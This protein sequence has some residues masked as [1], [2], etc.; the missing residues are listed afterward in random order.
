MPG[1]AGDRR[2]VPVALEAD[3]PEVPP[4][5]GLVVVDRRAGHRLAGADGRVAAPAEDGVE[6]EAHRVHALAVQRRRHELALTRALPVEQRGADAAGE[7]RARVVVAHPAA[8]ERQ[9]A[10]RRGEQ[11]GDAGARPERG[12][13]ERRLVG[14]RSFAAE[15]GDVAVHEPRVAG[16]QRHVV[17]AEA[18]QRR[19]AHVRDE[20]VGG[21]EQV[22]RGG[23]AVVRPEVEHDAALAAVVELEDRVVRQVVAEHLAELARRVA[24]RRLDLDDVGAPVGEHAARR[25]AGDPHAELHDLDPVQ[26]TR[27]RHLHDDQRGTPS[28]PLTNGRQSVEPIRA[29][30]NRPVNDG[31]AGPPTAGAARSCRRRSRRA[32]PSPWPRRASARS[33]RCPRPRPSARRPPTRAARGSTS[34]R[35]T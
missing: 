3:D 27:H 18:G 28:A 5:A 8:L 33:T 2:P 21:I 35:R 9:L 24:L 22:E 7:R 16:Q 20:H 26:R 4:A 1:E 29:G 19:A 31:V 15:T 12:D 34:R 23:L 17:E 32:R 25:R 30:P 11:V 14:I 13:V 10:A 6:V